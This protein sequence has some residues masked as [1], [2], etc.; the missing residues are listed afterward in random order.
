MFD[1][2]KMK[3]KKFRE[4]FSQIEVENLFKN[5]FYSILREKCRNTG[6]YGLEKNPI[7]VLKLKTKFVQTAVLSLEM[8][9]TPAC[10]D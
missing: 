6:K 4:F 3:D 9:F 8:L 10:S 1:Q 7:L 5:L 2:R